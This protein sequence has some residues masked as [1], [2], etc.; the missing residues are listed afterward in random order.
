MRRLNGQEIISE[1]ASKGVIL[2]IKNAL[3]GSEA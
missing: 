3:Y 2:Q 1:N